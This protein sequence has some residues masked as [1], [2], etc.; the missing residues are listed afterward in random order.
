MNNLP[1][2][3]ISTPVASTSKFLVLYGALG[4]NQNADFKVK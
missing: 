2:K 3:H 4:C 1:D